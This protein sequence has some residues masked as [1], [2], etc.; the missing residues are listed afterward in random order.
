MGFGVLS[1]KYLGGRNPENARITL[2]PHYKRYSNENAIKATQ[3]Y[4]ELAQAN[5][6]S[7]AQMALAFVNT[8]PFV[9]STIIGATGIKQLT[10]NIGSINV[11]L[12][13]DVLQG[14]EA[15]HHEI[16]NPAP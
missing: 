2:F 13:D 9:K 11:K 15:I 10:E 8:R 5:D 14:I 3:K 12:S 7:L 4:Y 16:P 6:L 1:G